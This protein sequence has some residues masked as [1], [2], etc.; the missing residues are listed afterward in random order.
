MFYLRLSIPVF[1]VACQASGDRWTSVDIQHPESEG[2]TDNEATE[3]VEIGFFAGQVEIV[4]KT[5]VNGSAEFFAGLY[6]PS[7]D[8][9]EEFHCALNFDLASE[10]WRSDCSD[11]E[12][13]YN[14]RAERVVVHVDD[15]SCEAYGFSEDALADFRFAM[16]FGG[17]RL[18]IYEDDATW[19]PV[20]ETY[21]SEGYTHFE[22]LLD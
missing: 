4:P 3:G 12:E 8:S 5:E 7:T 19:N 11:C 10:E 20:G 17:D 6:D 22:W 1:L 21:Y 13:A 15:G 9:V 14:F 2:S 16:G 18:Y